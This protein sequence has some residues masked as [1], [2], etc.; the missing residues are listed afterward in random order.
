METE[1]NE[2]L[3][4]KILEEKREKNFKTLQVENRYI[5]CIRNYADS[6]YGVKKNAPKIDGHFIKL[7]KEM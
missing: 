3:G 6:L 4:E 5:K 1:G 2:E 7:E